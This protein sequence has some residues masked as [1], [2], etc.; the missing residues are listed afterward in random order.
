MGVKNLGNS[1]ATQAAAWDRIQRMLRCPSTTRDHIADPNISTIKFAVDYTYN[2]NLGDD[3]SINA[4]DN[5]GYGVQYSICYS[6]KKRNQVPD[7]A[8]VALDAGSQL[9]KDDERF[10]T[11]T[12]LIT[13]DSSA[14]DPTAGR[15]VPKA[16]HPHQKNQANCLFHDGVVRLCKGFVGY[17][18]NFRPTSITATDIPKVTDLQN[19][20]IFSPGALIVGQQTYKATFTPADVWQKGRPLPF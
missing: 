2:T 14:S 10:A 13:A 3:R 20:M 19:Y 8:L 4:P 16:G 7:S 5:P 12:E 11:L 18:G 17:N 6:F 15:Y 9:C 1:Q